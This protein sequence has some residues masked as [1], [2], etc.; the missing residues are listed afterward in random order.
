MEINRLE[1]AWF[2]WKSSQHEAGMTG[3]M[4]SSSR[5]R[6]CNCQCFCCCFQLSQVLQLDEALGTLICP[7]C[8]F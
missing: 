5:L 6:A 2:R 7:R 3:A 1:P 8:L 4:L